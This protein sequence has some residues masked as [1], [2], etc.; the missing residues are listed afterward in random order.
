MRYCLDRSNLCIA[1][2]THTSKI[3]V[4]AAVFRGIGAAAAV[5]MNDQ[6]V[7]LGS[8]SLVLPREIFKT[9]CTHGLFVIAE[10][11]V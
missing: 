2:P 8:S 4:D 7:Y 9:H 3:N 6:G 10:D 11:D 5:W 1:A